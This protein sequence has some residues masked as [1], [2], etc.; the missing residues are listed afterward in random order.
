MVEVTLA[1]GLAA[2][3]LIVIFG[4]L[5]IGLN[6]NQ[7]ASQE[8]EASGIL[9]SVVADLKACPETSPT[10]QATQTLQYKIPVPANPV[11]ADSSSSYYFSGDGVSSG[12][13]QAD[14]KYKVEVTFRTNGPSAR[15][16]TLTYIKASWPAAAADPVGSIETLL[17]LD[18]N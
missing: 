14:S 18:R 17:A 3:C 1:L 15:A 10:G 7:A 16:A 2:F 9:S 6:S 5:P 11:G 12:S 4:L 13:L 8:T